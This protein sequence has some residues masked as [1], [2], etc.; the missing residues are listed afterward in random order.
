MGVFF[1]FAASQR[2]QRRVNKSAMRFAGE[3]GG[4][5]VAVYSKFPADFATSTVLAAGFK[6][7]NSLNR[8][9]VDN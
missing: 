1:R 9:K 7:A 8:R 5:H 4:M 6:A 3:K 2:T